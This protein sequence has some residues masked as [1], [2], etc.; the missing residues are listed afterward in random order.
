MQTTKGARATDK[1]PR[2]APARSLFFVSL[3]HLPALLL[4]MMGGKIVE[5]YFAPTE[6]AVEEDFG[7]SP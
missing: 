1:D 6:E 2:D 3:V 5:G 4:I 7:S